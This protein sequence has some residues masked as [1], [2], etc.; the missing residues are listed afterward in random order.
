M[1]ISDSPWYRKPLSASWVKC[2]L[3]PIALKP[4]SDWP[5]NALGLVM[6]GWSN[7]AI[8]QQL[9]PV[10]SIVD[11]DSACQTYTFK[12]QPM[13]P[14]AF[15]PTLSPFQEY[16]RRKDNGKIRI[17]VELQHY[18]INSRESH[19]YDYNKWVPGGWTRGNIELKFCMD[20]SERER[21]H[22]TEVKITP[23]TKRIYIFHKCISRVEAISTMTTLIHLCFV[24]NQ[25]E[26]VWFLHL[27]T[28][29]NTLFYSAL[30]DKGLP[31]VSMSNV[32]KSFIFH[33]TVWQFIIKRS[34]QRSICWSSLSYCCLWIL[35]CQRQFCHLVYLNINCLL[36]LIPFVVAVMH[37]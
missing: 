4:S 13:L 14:H 28:H 25:T 30:E 5:V 6:M 35:N 12:V 34:G 18:S 26:I 7:S 2:T 8:S 32:A 20:E 1:S 27:M 36:K 16:A 37:K 29:I 23:H 33:H 22:S 31:S 17:R 21:D 11:T 3:S 24:D 15:V 9:L 19:A 10:F